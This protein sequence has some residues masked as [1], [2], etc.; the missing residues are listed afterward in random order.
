[1]QNAVTVVA[2][3]FRQVPAHVVLAVDEDQAF[4]LVGND[5]VSDVVQ[6][7]ARAIAVGNIVACLV[8]RRR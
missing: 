7:A 4:C 1:M 6:D 8:P 2:L 3:R 5:L